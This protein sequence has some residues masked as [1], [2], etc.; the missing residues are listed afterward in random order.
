MNTKPVI[1]FPK[2]SLRQVCKAVTFP[3]P[4]EVLAHLCV[5]QDTLAATAGG[6]AFSSTQIAAEG[7]LVFVSAA[8]EGSLLPPFAINPTWEPVLEDSETDEVTDIEGCLSIP[9][10]VAPVKRWNKVR[11]TYD[12]IDS[13]IHEVVLSGLDARVVQH[14]TQHLQGGLIYDLVPK[15]VPLKA[16]K[17]AIQNRKRGL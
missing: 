4:D 2:P 16:Y 7:L 12:D 14:E 3:L 9:E 13:L 1:K 10:L 15:D 8:R 11:L 5:L 6:L 17:L